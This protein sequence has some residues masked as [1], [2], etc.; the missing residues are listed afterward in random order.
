MT[1]CLLKN[2]LPITSSI[3]ITMHSPS[4]SHNTTS[5]APT[6]APSS[7]PPAEL[8]DE[9]FNDEIYEE[10]DVLEEERKAR[11]ANER[12]RIQRQK[13]LAAKRKREREDSKESRDAKAKQ[14]DE[15]LAKSAVNTFQSALLP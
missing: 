13:K 10:K 5:T 3:S 8:P 14:L 4:T 9:N 7:P 6:T 2:I 11:L 12:D 15:L 1:F